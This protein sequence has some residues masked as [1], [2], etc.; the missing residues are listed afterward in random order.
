MTTLAKILKAVSM[1]AEIPGNVALLELK[2]APPEE[3]MLFLTKADAGKGGGSSLK[4]EMGR[5]FEKF[6]SYLITITGNGKSPLTGSCG[7]TSSWLDRVC[8]KLGAEV[9]MTSL[10][11]DQILDAL[12]Q[13]TVT[14]WYCRMSCGSH[15]FFIEHVDGQYAVYQSFHGAESIQAS[16]TNILEG[17]GVFN[18]KASFFRKLRGALL[19]GQVFQNTRQKEELKVAEDLSLRLGHR[20]TAKRINE[21]WDAQTKKATSRISKAIYDLATPIE[22]K[23]VASFDEAFDKIMDEVMA[24]GRYQ[25]EIFHGKE[26]KTATPSQF[27]LNIDPAIDGDIATNIQMGNLTNR[28]KWTACFKDTVGTTEARLKAL[29]INV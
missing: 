8:T 9:D 12:E 3:A 21:V 18:D 24:S 10:P 19:D 6:I 25:A 23:V 27:R 20:M 17:R 29:G 15:S 7:M 28:D 5:S 13:V 26:W 2:N 14:R 16:V 4:S 22:K 11:T 1:S